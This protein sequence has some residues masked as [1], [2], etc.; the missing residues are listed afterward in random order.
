MLEILNKFLP[1]E[2][3]SQWEEFHWPR[4]IC[5]LDKYAWLSSNDA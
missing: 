5:I 2:D 4:R 3:A 1:F